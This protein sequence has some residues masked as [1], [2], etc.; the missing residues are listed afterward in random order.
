MPPALL[1]QSVLP[2]KGMI[3]ST[4]IGLGTPKAGN[5]PASSITKAKNRKGE[6]IFKT[7]KLTAC[8]ACRGTEY[9]DDCDH[10]PTVLPSWK[11]REQLEDVK[12][13]Y[14]D[15]ID[16]FNRE[17]LG[18]NVDSNET[19]F[20]RRDLN[21]LRTNVMAPHRH[22][23]ISTIYV[24][25]DPNGCGARETGSWAALVSFFFN[26]MN[27]VL[28]GV[29]HHPTKHWSEVHTLVTSHI[30]ALRTVPCYR[31]ATIIFIPES[32]MATETQL[33][34]EKIVSMPRVCVAKEKPDRYGVRT[35][36]NRGGYAHRF[37]QLLVARAVSW[38]PHW[39][40]A[41]PLTHKSPAEYHATLPQV[42]IQELRNFRI[43]G[44]APGRADGEDRILLTGRAGPDGQF[45]TQLRD[46]LCMATLIVVYWAI[47]YVSKRLH[48]A[49]SPV[50][51]WPVI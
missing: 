5:C 47:E 41:N 21:F 33:V 16:D 51:D 45:N 46:D 2:L 50:G 12:A 18:R 19:I 27:V 43:H 13:M 29:D 32:N 26:G 14:G 6:P 4:I 24:G 8:E 39:I 3:D 22:P 49:E 23:D 35:G 7:L 38:H 1:F 31:A 17:M 34:S 20:D 42:F 44:Q 10:E 36:R 9:E 48:V 15:N 11:T 30:N 25:F 40:S 28:T 37:R